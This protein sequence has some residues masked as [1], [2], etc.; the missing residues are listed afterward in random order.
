[1]GVLR[2][3]APGRPATLLNGA[4]S[5]GELGVP[6]VSRMASAHPHSRA[7]QA[8]LPWAV[9]SLARPSTAQ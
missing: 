1:M 6:V 7:A 9:A 2:G 5:T 8:G 4:S 3:A